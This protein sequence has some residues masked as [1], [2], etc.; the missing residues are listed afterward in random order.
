MYTAQC[1][2]YVVRYPV[3]IAPFDDVAAKKHHV[4]FQGIDLAH[5]LLHEFQACIFHDMKIGY[6]GNPQLAER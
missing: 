4:G 5:K 3:F 6:K 2:Q 1:C